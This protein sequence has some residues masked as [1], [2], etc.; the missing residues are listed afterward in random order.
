[1]RVRNGIAEQLSIGGVDQDLLGGQSLLHLINTTEITRINVE[2]ITNG[3]IETAQ[4][5]LVAV[6]GMLVAAITKGKDD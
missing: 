5:V 2:R 3:D 1:M 6:I 4:A